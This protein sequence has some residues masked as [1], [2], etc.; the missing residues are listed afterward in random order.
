MT[1]RSETTILCCFKVA[2]IVGLLETLENDNY[3][4]SLREYGQN[5]CNNQLYGMY[6]N[7][8]NKVLKIKFYSSTQNE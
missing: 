7:T 1:I 5:I 4:I 2:Y 6:N 8:V 3:T